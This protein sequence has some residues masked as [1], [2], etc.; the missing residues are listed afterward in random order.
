[1][2]LFKKKIKNPYE[3]KSEK[4]H[5]FKNIAILSSMALILAVG[6]VA[7]LSA[8]TTNA[9]IT[10][11][12]TFTARDVAA[13]VYM[14]ATQVRSNDGSGDDV[15]PLSRMSNLSAI[16]VGDTDG[17]GYTGVVKILP[18]TSSGPSISIAPASGH[19]AYELAE[20]DAE[21]NL[22]NGSTTYASYMKYELKVVNR[23][24]KNMRAT[25]EVNFL[26]NNLTQ[27]TSYNNLLL[28]YMAQDT[29]NT[30]LTQI[31]S[32]RSVDIL[33]QNMS[34]ELSGVSSRYAT[35]VIWVRVD[36]EAFDANETSVQINLTLN[37]A[38]EEHLYNGV[39]TPQTV[40]NVNMD[41]GVSLA[42]S[43][44]TIKDANNNVLGTY[45][46]VTGNAVNVNDS[47]KYQ[48]ERVSYIAEQ[49]SSQVD[50]AS[51]VCPTSTYTIELS[52]ENATSDYGIML[53]IQKKPRAS[54]TTNNSYY[55]HLANKASI[56]GIVTAEKT[57]TF[58][59]TYV[60]NGG[61]KPGFDLAIKK[62]VGS[63][64]DNTYTT[65]THY[66]GSK[67]VGLQD[68]PSSLSGVV[69]L[70]A[71]NVDGYLITD[72]YNSS[73]N[74]SRGCLYNTTVTEVTVPSS[75]ARID[76][77][78]MYCS[79]LTKITISDGVRTIDDEAFQNCTNLTNISIPDSANISASYWD[80]PFSGCNNLTYTTYEGGKYLGN[81]QNPYLWLVYK[82]GSPTSLVIHDNAKH[83]IS[84]FSYGSSVLTSVTIPRGVE[85][86][87]DY[88]FYNCTGLTRVNY[89]GS[90]ADWVSISFGGSG[91]NPLANAHHLYINDTE[92]TALQIPAGVTTIKN[93]AFEGCTGLT[94]VTLPSSVT[95][96]NSYAFNGCTGLT[97]VNYAGSITG[98]LSMSFGYD[99]NPLANAH[100]LYINDT[101]VTAL[102]I[103][104][105]VTTINN[106]AFC[107]CT[108]L[109]SVT[110]PNSLTVIGHSAF[111]GCTGLTSVVIPSSVSE[112]GV[113]IFS[114]TNITSMTI[115]TTN[116][117]Y[118]TSEYGTFFGFA[119]GDTQANAI[120]FNGT[121]AQLQALET[122]EDNYYDYKYFRCS[123]NQTYSIRI[124]GY[125]FLP[126]TDITVWDDKKKR[127]TRKKIKDLKPEDK[128]LVWNFDEG[129]LDTAEILWQ[130][131]VKTATRYTKATFSDGGKLEVVGLNDSKRHAIF[132]KETGKFEYINKK[133]IGKT[134]VN[135]KG[136]D[137]K[138]VNI[139][140]VDKKVE[141][142]NV[143]TSKHFNCYA[144]G[145]L[146]ST[147]MNN[148]YEIQ[149]MRFV[150]D[151]RKVIKVAGLSKEEQRVYDGF[152]LG[153]RKIDKSNVLAEIAYMKQHI[154]AMLPEA[155]EERIDY[156]LMQWV[157]AQK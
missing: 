53:D 17:T 126:D 31:D 99:G 36:D 118:S 75:V 81:A 51:I 23:A 54:Y 149:D 148:L 82:D 73:S 125:C 112:M 123:N 59:A 154:S 130:S 7:V 116:F 33:A 142:Y 2:G 9:R 84:H 128:L 155:T 150:K 89:A 15:V 26:D 14:K 152:R 105:G 137:V 80:K 45:D 6:V 55:A 134:T 113:G 8:F 42:S 74:Y 87:G 145:Y 57:A 64:A 95:S 156:I 122:P 124:S 65:S 30:T 66:S 67:G 50:L 25:I 52:V 102:Q 68:C 24:S 91:S 32:G 94:S 157:M 151:G 110:F 131:K 107:G 76:S 117:S 146:T 119:A 60:Y 29:N 77:A 18:T 28:E 108:G 97:R 100:H 22:P 106:Y 143:V 133:L 140:F 62:I 19:S 61:I 90:I 39:E 63:Q 127:W 1:M 70:P 11:R 12:L 121:Y 43:T 47:G 37:A 144:N 111:Q 46:L 3:K 48:A 41:S 96:I 120:I 79:S 92:V 78:F 86:F 88:A 44:M 104:A 40:L 21:L 72:L 147:R 136:E 129:K 4:K 71:Y 101:E 49:M 20:E 56:A 34:S 135:E 139:E 138:V 153:E 35:F 103:P 13:N 93:N 83:V 98:W 58:K 132:I 141:Y 16:D 69:T 85:S 114:G 115:N 109:T 10:T 27:G 5:V 38:D